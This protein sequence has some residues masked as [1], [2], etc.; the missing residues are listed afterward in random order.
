MDK[1]YAKD[2]KPFTPESLDL[3]EPVISN[4]RLVVISQELSSIDS[5]LCS[6]TPDGI[7]TINNDAVITYLIACIN[8]LKKQVEELQKP[9]KQTSKKK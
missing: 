9:K 8:D 4:N 3:P 5:R 7:L 1:R 6:K 2:I